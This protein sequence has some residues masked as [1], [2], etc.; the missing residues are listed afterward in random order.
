MVKSKND[1]SKKTLQN[2]DGIG[3]SKVYF[4]V[5]SEV[6]SYLKKDLKWKK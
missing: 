6:K 1:C 3:M 2:G 4:S 5:E